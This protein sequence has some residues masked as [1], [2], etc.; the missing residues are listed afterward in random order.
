MPVKRIID[1]NGA[2]EFALH[3]NWCGKEHGLGDSW[4]VSHIATGYSVA[5]GLRMCDAINEATRRVRHV[6]PDVM[7]RMVAS[8]MEANF[9]RVAVS[10]EVL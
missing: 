5:G 3:R 10:T 1:I 7:A 4:V 6:G 8:A 2:R 9:K